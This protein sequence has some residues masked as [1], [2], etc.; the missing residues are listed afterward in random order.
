[1]SWPKASEVQVAKLDSNLEG[2]AERRKMFGHPCYFLKGNMIAGVFGDKVFLRLPASTMTE[3]ES[4]GQAEP[5]VP[6][7]GRPMSAYVQM[8]DP[9]PA[10]FQAS[11]RFA[12]TL[13]EKAKKKK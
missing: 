1:M 2:K 6:T 8:D 3:L 13:P 12:E 9:A 10:L 7:P 5:F 4:S 11:L